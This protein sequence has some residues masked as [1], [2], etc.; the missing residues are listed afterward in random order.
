M[1]ICY[2]TG[3]CSVHRSEHQTYTHEVFTR[4]R[5][6]GAQIDEVVVSVADLASQQEVRVN[7][8]QYDLLLIDSLAHSAVI[9]W[10][11]R[12][13]AQRPLVVFYYNLPVETRAEAPLLRAD[14]FITLS[15]NDRDQLVARGVRREQIMIAPAGGNDDA[16]WDA[17]SDRVANAL[18]AAVMARFSRDEHN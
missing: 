9:P 8:H 6:T 16:A 7:P 5:L 13:H 12:W 15:R 11:D 17:T 2:I 3:D 4:L 14:W 18:G 1:R 10:L